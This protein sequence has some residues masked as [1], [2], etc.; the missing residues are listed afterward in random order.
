MSQRLDSLYVGILTVG[1]IALPANAVNS[2]SQVAAG[3]NI[4]SGKVGQEP[5]LN[6]AQAPGADIA[7]ATQDLTICN[8]AGTIDSVQA[9]V[10][11]VQATG[12]RSATVMVQKSTGGGA[13]ANVL[14][15]VITLD[16]SATIRVAVSGTVSVPA[17][18]AGDVLR[19]VVTQVAGTTGTRPPGAAG[20]RD[21]EEGGQPLSGAAGAS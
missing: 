6:Y 9:V 2:D 17:F 4:D 3:A 8:V 1:A 20:D 12:D 10:T 19:V 7:T 11:G 13:F 5:G 18:A 21:P 14:S 15:A 16:S